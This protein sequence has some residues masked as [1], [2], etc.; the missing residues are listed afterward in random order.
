M[1]LWVCKVREV[2]VGF[3]FVIAFEIEGVRVWI[4]E[5]RKVS[6]MA[7]AEVSHSQMRRQK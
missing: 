2:R 3:G 5:A 1:R 7:Y 6:E 4:C